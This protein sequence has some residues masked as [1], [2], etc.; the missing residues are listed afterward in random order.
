MGIG[1]RAGI[2]VGIGGAR[3]RREFGPSLVDSGRDVRVV[4][5]LTMV[6]ADKGSPGASTLAVLLAATHPNRPV[7]VEADPAGGDLAHRLFAVR[8]VH[9]RVPRAC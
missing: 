5:C 4:G 7:L 3:H 2:T 8:V 1:H 9:T 6:C